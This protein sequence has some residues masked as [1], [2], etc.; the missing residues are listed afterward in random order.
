VCLACKNTQLMALNA[1]GICVCKPKYGVPW[2][3]P[4]PPSNATGGCLLLY[5]SRPASPQQ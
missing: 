5:H 4:D 3:V 1:D 2:G